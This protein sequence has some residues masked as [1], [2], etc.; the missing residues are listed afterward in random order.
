MDAEGTAPPALLVYP[1][2]VFF[3]FAVS[4]LSIGSAYAKSGYNS[5]AETSDIRPSAW[6]G[7]PLQSLW[8]RL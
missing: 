7:L 6:L 1:V 8:E 4:W 3:C 2:R 5:L